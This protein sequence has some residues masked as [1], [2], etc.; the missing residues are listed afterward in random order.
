MQSLEALSVGSF[1]SPI[2]RNTQRFEIKINVKE[3]HTAVVIV[4]NPKTLPDYAIPRLIDVGIT[5]VG[6]VKVDR[7]A[8]HSDVLRL[9]SIRTS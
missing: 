3:S 6:G 2:A 9:G 7:N 4:P 1:A 5:F 8:R